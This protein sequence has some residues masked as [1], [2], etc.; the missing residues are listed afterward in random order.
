M[1]EAWRP[2]GSER[3]LRVGLAGLGSM[4]RNHLRVLRTRPGC[5]LVAV[6]DPIEE[7][8][9][10]AMADPEPAGRP[11]TGY[12]EPLAMIAEADLDAVVLAAPTTTH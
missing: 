8:L 11:P 4:G 9:A 1:A 3:E 7:M 5:R 10:A 12:L 2:A 6:A